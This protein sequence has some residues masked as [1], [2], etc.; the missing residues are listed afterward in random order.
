M[1]GNHSEHDDTGL[2]DDEG[3]VIDSGV[4]ATTPH[5]PLDDLFAEVDRELAKRRGL[6][7]ENEARLTDEGATLGDDDELFVLEDEAFGVEPAAADLTDVVR[8]NADAAP[9]TFLA[10]ASVF[11]LEEAEAERANDDVLDV[12]SEAEEPVLAADGEGEL[13]MIDEIDASS[14]ELEII[15]EERDPF[16]N[17][18]A[19]QSQGD[20][21]EDQQLWSAEDPAVSSPALEEVSWDAEQ[22]QAT[23]ALF[24]EELD[25]MDGAAGADAPAEDDFDPIYGDHGAA[26]GDLETVGQEQEGQ[27]DFAEHEETFVDAEPALV[28]V[29]APT[30]VG[31]RRRLRLF[32]AAALLL[33]AAG[34]TLAVIRPDL[35]RP[36]DGGHVIDRVEIARPITEVVMAPPSPPV[37]AAVDPTP[38]VVVDTTPPPVVATST[39]TSPPVAPPV[40]PVAEVQTSEPSPP[41]PPVAVTPP[42]TPPPTVPPASRD[43]MTLGEDLIVRA[44]EAPA[45]GRVHALADGIA[46]GNQAFA[47]LKNLNY[48]VG[49]VKAMDAT[50]I[51]LTLDPGEVTLAFDD[52]S[53]IVPLASEEYRLMQGGQDSFVRLRNNNRLFGKI[54]SNGTLADNIV[55][56][57]QKNQ[58]TIPRHAIEEIGGQSTLGVQV[59]QDD[60]GKWVEKLL[61]RSHTE[62]GV[63]AAPERLAPTGPTS[64]QPGK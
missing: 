50:V 37:V 14:T 11:E 45:R 41:P 48:F 10:N 64:P 7:E 3:F 6:W 26:H 27:P 51:T 44:A 57:V 62:S 56:E 17:L 59:L 43:S 19:E 22:T 55:I 39:E 18:G 8:V 34:A 36:G 40:E 13:A 5:H 58:V 16:A 24:A 29:G 30:G 61:R 15:E 60:G 52:L 31:R 20:P 23:A 46:T 54:L 32:A 33:V 21:A 25:G 2:D 49:R 35:L 38:T 4:E 12:G 42:P 9:D 1:T 63:T 47:Q 53:A 28:V